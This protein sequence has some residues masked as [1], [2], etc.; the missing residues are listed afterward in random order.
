MDNDLQARE[1]GR[2]GVDIARSLLFVPGDRPDR[3]DKA[4]TSGADGVI[5]DLEDA[6]AAQTK[7]SARAAVTHWL[8]G[9]GSA[10]VR[11]NAPG[12]DWHDDDRAAVAGLRG[13]TAVMVPKAEN[14][15]DMA[16][17]AAALGRGTPI[18][19]LIETAL[20]IHRAHEIAATAGV[21]RLAF[22]ALD[23]ALDTRSA[24]D[25]DAA[26]LYARSSLVVASRVAR[27]PPPI[28][29][30][31]TCL[32]DEAAVRSAAS[33]ARRLGFGG[34]LCVHPRQVVPVNA[35][36]TP[37]E[38]EIHHARRIVAAAGDGV[39]SLNGRMVD[40]PVVDHARMVLTQATLFGRR[41]AFDK[42][43]T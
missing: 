36:F 42:R 8:A 38:E 43:R 25:E 18:V 39:T 14:P 41:T 33:M 3:F 37:T 4:A 34:K 6:V 16:A 1:P 28:D 22:G 13:L 27:I 30:V 23:F 9:S 26:L 2:P 35:A 40:K 31:T 32:G 12:T 20:G 19:A 10:A 7:A 11:I 29:G 21:V 17:L 24:A 5:C 15:Q